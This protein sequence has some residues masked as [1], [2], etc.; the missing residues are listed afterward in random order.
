LSRQKPLTY[1]DALLAI[2]G[3]YAKWVEEVFQKDA[4]FVTALDKVSTGQAPTASVILI[5][6]TPM[7]TDTGLSWPCHSHFFIRLK[8]HVILQGLHL[9]F[10]CLKWVSLYKH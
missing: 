10:L 7:A 5:G 4:S 3:K 8:Y 6:S 1:V 2:H 9:L